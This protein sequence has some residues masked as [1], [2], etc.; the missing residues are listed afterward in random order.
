MPASFG[1][2]K[3]IKKNIYVYI[4]INKKEDK[5]REIKN[6]GMIQQLTYLYSNEKYQDLGEL[7][8][9]MKLTWK[10]MT[11]DTERYVERL[12]Q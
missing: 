10:K 11:N 3:K 8:E 6:R 9:N 5:N 7:G 1:D 12:E 2:Q 4:H